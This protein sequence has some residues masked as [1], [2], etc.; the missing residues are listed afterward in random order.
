MPLFFNPSSAA[1]VQ[2]TVLEKVRIGERIPVTP[3][4]DWATLGTAIHACLAAS[5]TDSDSPITEAEVSGILSGFNVGDA[6]LSS[7]VHRQINAFHAWV[8]Q[9]LPNFRPMAEAFSTQRMVNGQHLNGRIDLLLDTPEGYILIDHKSSPLAMDKWDGLAEEYGGQLAAYSQ[10]VERVTG[11][12]VKE[13]WL[14]MPI[15]GGCLNVGVLT[16]PE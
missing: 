2:T 16:H 6:V 9:R 12:K 15:A 13:S 5:F 1:Q 3:G 11:R 8:K 4:V 14:F 7:A 10:T